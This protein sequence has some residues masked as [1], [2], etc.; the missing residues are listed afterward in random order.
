MVWNEDVRL[1]QMI[2][3]NIRIIDSSSDRNKVKKWMKERKGRYCRQKKIDDLKKKS[4]KKKNYFVAK[5]IAFI[6]SKWKIYLDIK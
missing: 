2:K 6:F 4:K 3:D 1:F 5:N